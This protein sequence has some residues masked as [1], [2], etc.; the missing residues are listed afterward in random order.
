VPAPRECFDH[1][2]ETIA[3]SLSRPAIHEQRFRLLLPVYQ[4]KWCCILLNDFL[5]AGDRRRQ[6]ALPAS[7]QEERRSQQLSKARAALRNA[8]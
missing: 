5:P 1:F 2:A 8:A 7:Q 3:T 6:F 4:I